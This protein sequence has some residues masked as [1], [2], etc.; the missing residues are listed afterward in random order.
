MG[1]GRTAGVALELSSRPLPKA[2]SDSAS[3]IDH[4]IKS[5]E[6]KN[7]RNTRAVMPNVRLLT[8]RPTVAPEAENVGIA[9]T[10]TLDAPSMFSH[11]IKW[12]IT[13]G[14]CLK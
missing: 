14:K 8:V 11:L 5:I 3:A 13:A 7:A 4:H 2:S 9:W 6:T 1:R 10:I 12:P